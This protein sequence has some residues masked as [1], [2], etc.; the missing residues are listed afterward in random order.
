MLSGST[1]LRHLA[2][3]Y[4]AIYKKLCFL[5]AV[6]ALDEKNTFAKLTSEH[7]DNLLEMSDEFIDAVDSDLW[8]RLAQ[9]LEHVLKLSRN[10]GSR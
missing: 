2:Q 6:A 5:L 9:Q 4:C 10:Q 3:F 7:M 1:L 8:E